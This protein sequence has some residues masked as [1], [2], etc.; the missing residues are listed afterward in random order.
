MS[1]QPRVPDRPGS[2]A[3]EQTPLRLG[4]W[5]VCDD[6][7]VTAGGWRGSVFSGVVLVGALGIG[8]A[9][10]SSGPS[11]AAAG[12]CGSVVATPPPDSALAVHTQTIKDGENSGYPSLDHGATAFLNALDQHSETAVQIAEDQIVAACNSLHIPL[13]TLTPP[14]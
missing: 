10:C 1:G 4:K 6:V 14:G 7:T 11:T 9:G 8:T 13:G 12:L 2:G 5:R 3:L